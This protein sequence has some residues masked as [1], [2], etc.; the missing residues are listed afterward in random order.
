MTKG[1]DVSLS[2][3]SVPI[4]FILAILGINGCSS[5]PPVVPEEF[6][7]Q[8]DP[9]LSF[10]DIQNAPQNYQ[11]RTVLLGGE[12]LSAKRR[13]EGTEFEIL[14]LPVTTDDP[15]A[16]RRSASEG[17]FLAL[18]RAVSD[19]ASL[20]PGTRVTLVGAVTGDEMRPLDEASYRYPMVDVKHLYVWEADTYRERSRGSVGLFGGMG[21]GFGSGS[22][23]GSFGGVGIGTGTGF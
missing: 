9:S 11:G 10:R 14:Q 23:S 16:E 2:R 19:P 18:D 15:P 3:L 5:G 7:A 12:I 8:I 20:P 1:P 4:G 21:F 17:R 6:Q 13:Q 22:R